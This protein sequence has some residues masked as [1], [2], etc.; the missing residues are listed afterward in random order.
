MLSKAQFNR[1]SSEILPNPPKQA[2][3][4]KPYLEDEAGLPERPKPGNGK[5]LFG[6]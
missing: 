2:G 5:G 6:R 4:V 3:K 1:P